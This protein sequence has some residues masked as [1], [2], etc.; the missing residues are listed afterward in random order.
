MWNILFIVDRPTSKTD[1]FHFEIHDFVIS[2]YS[3]LS[4]VAFSADEEAMVGLIN[5]YINWLSPKT[6]EG[7]TLSGIT[8][9][10]WKLEH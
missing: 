3:L 5:C 10:G 4:I 7:I 1:N 8:L 2:W 9:N 6:T